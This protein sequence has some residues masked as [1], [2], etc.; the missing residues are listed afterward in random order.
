L[1]AWIPRIPATA[2]LERAHVNGHPALLVR[3]G[4]EVDT[5]VAISIEDGRIAGLYAVRNPDKLSRVS[6][7]T[8]LSR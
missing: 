7:E 1:C 2:S 5:V 6:R 4:A 3:Y 8:A